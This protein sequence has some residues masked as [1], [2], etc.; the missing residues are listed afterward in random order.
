MVY[1]F[2]TAIPLINNGNG[3]VSG[4]VKPP[5]VKRLPDILTPAQISK[6]IN[7]TKKQR[8]QVFFLTLYSMGLRLSEGLHLTIHDI[9]SQTMQVH[10]REAKGGKDRFVP[11]PKRTL[12]A[13]LRCKTQQQGRCAHCHHDDRLP[14]SCGHRHYPQCQHRTTSDWLNR[15]KQKILPVH[16]YGYLHFTLWAKETGSLS[17]QRPISSHV[18]GGFRCTKRFGTTTK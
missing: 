11:L 14:L 7:A 18:L 16:L 10:I 17:P 9:D 8:Y 13:L 12:S 5:Q 2:S 3:S 15:Q 6:L 4:I 1:S